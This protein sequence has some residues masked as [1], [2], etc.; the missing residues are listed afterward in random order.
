[1]LTNQDSYQTSYIRQKAAKQEIGVSP[2]ALEN[3][4]LRKIWYHD[5]LEAVVSGKEIEIQ[6]FEGK[7]VRVLFQES[8]NN[9]PRFCVIVAADHPE[10][11]IVT[12]FNFV[13]GKFEYLEKQ[14]CWRRIK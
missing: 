1:M 7:N 8:T 14:K 11:Q 5:A 4:G 9:T 6:T 12:V 3:M 13:E 10:V 2:H